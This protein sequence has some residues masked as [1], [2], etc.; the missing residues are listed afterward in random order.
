MN[1]LPRVLQGSGEVCVNAL[2]RVL[3]GSVEVCVNALPRVLQGSGEEA[4]CHVRAYF[5]GLREA[6]GRQEATALA[7]VDSHVRQRLATLKQQHR[8]T[9]LLLA[10]ISAACHQCDRMLQEVSGVVARWRHRWSLGGATDGHQ[11][12]PPVANRQRHWTG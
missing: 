3:Q 7:V 10:Q 11:V 8:D 6:L 2:P 4:C 12:A 1:A 5:S 9:T